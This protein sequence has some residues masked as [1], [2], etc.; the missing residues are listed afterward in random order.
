MVTGVLGRRKDS[1]LLEGEMTGQ[2]RLDA[3]VIAIVVRIHWK[4]I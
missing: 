2:M 1:Q 3:I 4:V